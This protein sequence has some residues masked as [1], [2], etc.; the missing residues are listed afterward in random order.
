MTPTQKQAMEMA[1]SALADTPT[2]GESPQWDIEKAAYDALRTALAEPA[3][4]PVAWYDGNKFYATES[5]AYMA[6]ADIK[7][8]RPVCTPQPAV[9][10]VDIEDL[11]HSALQEALS[12]GL[13]LDLFVRYFKAVQKA[14]PP[15]EAPLLTDEEMMEMVTANAGYGGTNFDRVARAIEQAVRQKAGL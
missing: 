14:S 7:N 9:E 3:V 4:E 5:A 11:A 13:G 15:A 10:P 12:Y 2:D 6:C 1:I 8:L